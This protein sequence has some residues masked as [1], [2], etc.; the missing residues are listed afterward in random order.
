MI[1]LIGLFPT[2]SNRVQ[3]VLEELELPYCFLK[4]D[5]QAGDTRSDAFLNLN[6]NGKIPV[7]RDGDFVLYE[8]AAIANYLAD[9][10]GD[11]RLI[12]PVGT[13][14]RGSYYQWMFYCTTE[15]EQPLWTAGKHKFAL[16]EE[17]RTPAV[18]PAV[19]YEFDRAY[20]VLADHLEGREFMVGE[21]L[22]CADIFVAHTLAWANKAGMDMP[23]AHVTDYMTRMMARPAFKR[24]AAKETVPFSTA[25]G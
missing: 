25:V 18:M 13:K 6:P 4:V 3:W 12:P 24:M 16:P 2:R 23:A 8:S 19:K 5:F 1:E 11:G 22:T 7:L 14:L 10:Y 20:K 17:L 9:T 21:S 15:L